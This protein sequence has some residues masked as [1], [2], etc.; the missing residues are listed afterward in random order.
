MHN[1]YIMPVLLKSIPQ[2]NKLP[3]ICP[4]SSV[5]SKMHAQLFLSLSQGRGIMHY[6]L[7]HLLLP[8]ALPH[9]FL[10]KR[11]QVT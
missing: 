5:K 1:A 9:V 10:R 11:Q 8:R 2:T 3:S 6:S 4:P 7:F